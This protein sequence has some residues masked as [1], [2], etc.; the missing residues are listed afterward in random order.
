MRWGNFS[1]LQVVLINAAAWASI[2]I[3]IGKIMATLPAEKFDPNAWPFKLCHWESPRLY[4]RYFLISKWKS[5]LPDGARLIRTGFRK[6]QLSATDRTYLER[7]RL[8]TVR[9]EAT[10][11]LAIPP[12]ALFFL[13]NVPTVAIWMPLYAIAV[14]A[15]CIAVQRYNRIRINRVLAISSARPRQLP[16]LNVSE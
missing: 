5:W 3:G 9:A 15:P 1:P 16:S 6:R 14:N 4:R 10:H 11:W 13:W 2:Q 7:F 8:E 12:F